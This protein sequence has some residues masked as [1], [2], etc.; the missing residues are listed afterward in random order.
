MVVSELVTYAT[1][2]G[3]RPL[4]LRLVRRGGMITVSVTGPAPSDPAASIGGQTDGPVDGPAEGTVDPLQLITAIGSGWSSSSAGGVR[5]LWA[6]VDY[7]PP[8]MAAGK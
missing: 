1:M 7:G 2:E 5:R 3:E 6:T 4:D 8:P